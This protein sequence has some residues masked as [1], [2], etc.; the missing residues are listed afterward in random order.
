LE[1]KRES[2]ENL[3]DVFGIL[4]QFKGM[5]GKAQ[6]MWQMG[7]VPGMSNHHGFGCFGRFGAS[8]RR[9]KV[10]NGDGDLVDENHVTR[11]DLEMQGGKVARPGLNLGPH[12]LPS[13]ALTTEPPGCN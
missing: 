1:W 6:R 9:F 11:K 7:D 2:F 5:M 8:N 10:T 12:M 13:I 3:K 4:L